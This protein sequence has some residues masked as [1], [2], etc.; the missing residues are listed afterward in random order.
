VPFTTTMI[1][2]SMIAWSEY[3]DSVTSGILSSRNSES[4]QLTRI[5]SPFTTS[6]TSNC[7]SSSC[8]PAFLVPHFDYLI[9]LSFAFCGFY[10]LLYYMS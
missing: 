8:N 2:L 7:Y 3:Y 10:C 1:N 5:I 4:R 6:I 9:F